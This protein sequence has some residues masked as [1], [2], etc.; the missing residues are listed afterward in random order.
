MNADELA[1]ATSKMRR[2]SGTTLPH[3]TIA[4]WSGK[5]QAAGCVDGLGNQ[6]QQDDD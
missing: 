6:R 2:V 3:G 1:I 4:N 5:R